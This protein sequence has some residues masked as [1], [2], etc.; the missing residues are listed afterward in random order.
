LIVGKYDILVS[1]KKPLT[2]RQLYRLCQEHGSRNV[3]ETIIAIDNKS[4]ALDKYTNA[5]STI[6][7]WIKYRKENAKAKR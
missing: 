1:M 4:D 7:G 3:M 2:V 5:E 6:E